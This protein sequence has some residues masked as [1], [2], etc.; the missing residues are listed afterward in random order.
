MRHHLPLV[1][2]LLALCA[3]NAQ[4]PLQ[5]AMQGT[6]N[7]LTPAAAKSGRLF[8]SEPNTGDVYLYDVP[9]L[10]LVTILQ[11]FHQPQGEC[12]DNLGNVWVVDAGVDK[13]FKLDY[14]G[15][16][17]GELRDKRG[18][19][20]SCAWDGSTGNLAVTNSTVNRY[21][22]AVLVYRQALGSPTIVRNPR[23]ATY[24]FDGYDQSG[25]LYVDG[26]NYQGKFVLSEVIARQRTAHS[27][28]VS[29]AKI[30]L[31]G[32]VQWDA[33][34]RLL[35]VGDQNCGNARTTC[36]Y[37][38]HVLGKRA[39]IVNEIDLQ[40]YKASKVCDVVEAVIFSG[41]IYGSDDESC[42]YAENAT[43]NW[44]YPAGGDPTQYAGKNLSAPFGA[45]VAINRSSF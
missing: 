12:A 45:A 19:P 15:K 41:N 5:P 21:S 4:A 42:G 26:A 36:I 1:L 18:T 10:N 24:D 9:S 32:F 7:A 38:M 2:T 23:Q 35:D 37:Q 3:C 13:I 22:G 39:E 30:F 29:G 27:I 14:A 8:V 6:S 31:P 33:K 17:I 25:D 28:S 44:R 11:T 43:Y 20:Y 34:S 16:S 40:S